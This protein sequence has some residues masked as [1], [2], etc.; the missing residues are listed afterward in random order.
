MASILGKP[1]GPGRHACGRAGSPRPGWSYRHPPPGHGLGRPASLRADPFVLKDTLS[2]IRPAGHGVSVK[3]YS[4]LRSLF[5]AALQLAGVID[6]SGRGFA[7]RHPEWGPLIEAVTESQRLS[8]HLA[9]RSGRPG[10]SA[11]PVLA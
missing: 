7:R 9:G 10:R 1:G 2:R 8:G 6:S 3:S 11:I 5:A 4:N